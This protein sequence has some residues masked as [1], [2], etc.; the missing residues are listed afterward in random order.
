MSSYQTIVVELGTSRIKVGFAGESKP[1]RVFN[2]GGFGGEWSVGVSDGML[3][4][5]CSW[6]SF[7]L[8]LSP[9]SSTDSNR[10]SRTATTVYDWEKTLYPLFSHILTSVLFVQRPSRHRM[11]LLVNDIYPPRHF[12]E[13][14]NRVVLEYLGVGGLWLVKGGVFESFCYL[15]E[16]VSQ[17]LSTPLLPKAHMLVD[18]GTF[19]ARIMVTVTGSSILIDTYQ[20]T[21]SGYH[22]FLNKALKNFQEMDEG[23]EDSENPRPKSPLR[24]MEDANAVVQAWISLC[25][26]NET[27]DTT[28]ISVKL[29]SPQQQ[30]QPTKTTA[31]AS[32]EIPLQPL[33]RAF[34][35]VYLDCANPSSLI[36]C[37]LTS[38]SKCPID[39]RKAALQNVV[40]L[41]GGSVALR[42]FSLPDDIKMKAKSPGGLGSQLEMAARSAC[43]ISEDEKTEDVG[44]EEKKEDSS[45][46][47]SSIARLRFRSLRCAVDGTADADDSGK[48]YGGVNVRNPEPFAADMVAWIGGSIMGT[49]GF[50]HYEKKSNR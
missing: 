39:Y 11:L 9:Y 33:L 26:S 15:I 44:Q 40:L 1:R 14:L 22:S 47:I 42:H 46:S 35:D 41:G 34:Y 10:P 43:G 48:M 28:T 49:L 23:I 12:C 45:S 2:N 17:Q 27:M 16:G 31:S 30:S 25:S 37:M 21:M 19:E 36:F 50:K 24:S 3:S 29:P 20:S 32:I 5:A 18:I 38:A 4:R 8:Y 13:A 7:C 6:T